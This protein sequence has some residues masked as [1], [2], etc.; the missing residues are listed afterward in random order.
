MQLEPGLSNHRLGRALFVLVVC[1]FPFEVPK[2]PYGCHSPPMNWKSITAYASLNAALLLGF[3]SMLF[4]LTT[5][6]PEAEHQGLTSAVCMG[7]ASVGLVGLAFAWNAKW[8]R[9][10]GPVALLTACAGIWMAGSRLLS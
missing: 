3:V 9:A 8:I 2:G 1:V 7:I 5:Y 6:V 10:L 4:G